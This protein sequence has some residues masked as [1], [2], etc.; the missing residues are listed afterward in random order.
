MADERTTALPRAPRRDHITSLPIVEVEAGRVQTLHERFMA[1]F[2]RLGLPVPPEEDDRRFHCPNIT[3][4]FPFEANGT[5]FWADVA[6]DTLDAKRTISIAFEH[7]T[8]KGRLC[9]EVESGSCNTVASH[10]SMIGAGARWGGYVDR[11]VNSEGAFVI[12]NILVAQ[13]EKFESA[14]RLPWTD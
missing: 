10:R 12:A 2:R 8:K 3:A 4:V 11:E 9:L 14:K 7:P 5:S 1:A 6:Y 13:F